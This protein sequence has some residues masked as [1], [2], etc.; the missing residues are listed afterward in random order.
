MTEQLYHRTDHLTCPT[1]L[2]FKT[3]N[4]PVYRVL[5][6]C[7]LFFALTEGKSTTGCLS[8]LCNKVGKELQG[9]G[10]DF[11]GAEFVLGKFKLYKGRQASYKEPA[12]P[13]KPGRKL[14]EAFSQDRKPRD[15]NEG[16]NKPLLSLCI[17]LTDLNLTRAKISF[18]SPLAVLYGVQR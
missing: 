7:V 1:A 14:C 4:L 3:F 11:A 2:F 15:I 12:T 8:V 17:L 10:F 9:S 18:D 6:V 16:R 13:Y 5:V